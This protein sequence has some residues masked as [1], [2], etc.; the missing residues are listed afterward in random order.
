MTIEEKYN[1]TLDFIY[2]YI[3]HSMTR[4][5]MFHSEEYNL[6]RMKEMMDM[7]GNP[8]NNYPKIHIAGTKGKGSIAAFICS[9]L[10]KQGYKTGLYTSPHLIDFEERIRINFSPISKNELIEIVDEI[11]PI[12]EKFENVTTF[13]IITMIGFI[14]FSKNKVDI[15]VI[16]VG[17]GGRL[18]ATN[19]INP[20][21]SIIS[22]LAIDH[23]NFLGDSIESIAFEKS[24]II[25]K[26]IPVVLAKQE[27]KKSINVVHDIAN[28]KNSEIIDLNNFYII[29]KISRGIN[30]QKFILKYKNHKKKF[31]IKML[32]DFQIE[33]CI[34]AYF[35]LLKI[36]KIIELSEKSIINGLK[37]AL[38][39]GRFE[40][41]N[42]KP[43]VIIDSAHNP[44]AIRKL[45]ESL[46]NYF[47]NKKFILIFGVSIDKNVNGM[48]E[49]LKKET[50]LLIASDSK[51]PK[52]MEQSKIQ[53]IAK[54]YDINTEFSENASEALK[55]ALEKINK[56][57]IIVCTGSVFMAASLKA[58]FDNRNSGENN[59]K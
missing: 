25:K 16:E 8:Q 19:I 30:S 57:E 14:A 51:H 6:S 11:K 38:W 2:S 34:T 49:I 54:K 43:I 40:I 26:D 4:Q 15:A 31:K 35:S 41:L 3:N 47:P 13:E 24:G 42:K 48:I 39:N 44:Y 9:A 20:I 28:S 18:D 22:P 45:K 58:I 52:A 12:I 29:S 17:L 53:Q 10:I 27:Y 23:T 33:N 59:A 56:N 46:N 21:L 5:K 37:E 50:K 55:I 7:V 1:E 32:G 36:S